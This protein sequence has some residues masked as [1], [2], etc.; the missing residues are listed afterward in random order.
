MPETEHHTTRLAA[1]E[2]ALH[3]LI[4]AIGDHDAARFEAR[5]SGPQ[6]PLECIM[7]DDL[8]LESVE[9]DRL[10]GIASNPVRCA[11]RGAVKD[12]GRDLFRAAGNTDAMLEVLHRVANRDPVNAGRRGAIIDSAWNG[13]GEGTDR[14]WS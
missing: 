2:D 3:A 11:L 13:L 8:T 7:L 14:W 5:R 12:I 4:T 10:R 9:I 1:M 6:E